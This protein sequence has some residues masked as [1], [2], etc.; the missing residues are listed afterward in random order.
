MADRNRSKVFTN[1]LIVSVTTEIIEELDILD[2]F[3]Y[4]VVVE[5]SVNAHFFEISVLIME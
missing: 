4:R 1:L 2:H 5:D 3:P